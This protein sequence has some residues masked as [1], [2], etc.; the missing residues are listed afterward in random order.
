MTSD[1]CILQYVHAVSYILLG[2]AAFCSS[3]GVSYNFRLC[4]SPSI[5]PIDTPSVLRQ[6]SKVVE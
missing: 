2:K 4:G 6:L 1:C 5:Q 3:S